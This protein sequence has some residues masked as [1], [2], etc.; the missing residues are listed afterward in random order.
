MP[1]YEG[2]RPRYK[3]CAFLKKRYDLLLSNKVEF[4]CECQEFS[5]EK[6]KHIDKRYQTFFRMSLIQN[7]ESIERNGMSKFLE[8]QEVRWRCPKCG[9]AICCHNGLCFNCDLDEYVIR[10]NCICWNNQIQ[11]RDI[12]CLI[13]RNLGRRNWQTRKVCQKY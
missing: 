7:L 10:T 3:K 11:R 1:Y 9:E 13:K 4:C 8:S 6:L 2:C 12:L 5:C